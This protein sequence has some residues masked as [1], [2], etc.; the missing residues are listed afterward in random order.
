MPDDTLTVPGDEM[1]I[2]IVAIII[3]AVFVLFILAVATFMVVAMRRRYRAAK[4]AGLDPFAGDIEVMAQV[5][6]SALLAADKPLPERL[7]AI[8]ELHR[9]GI[10]SAEERDVARSRI[11]D[12]AV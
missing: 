11:L 4:R 3:F 12:S 10:I 2:G 5:K 7:A 9:T 1:A 6:N 8:N